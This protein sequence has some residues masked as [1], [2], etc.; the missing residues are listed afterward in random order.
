MAVS[1]SDAW[2]DLPPPPSA[3]DRPAADHMSA[4]ASR[5][6]SPVGEL[7]EDAEL[8]TQKPPPSPPDAAADRSI[9]AYPHMESMLQEFR[10]WRQEESRRCTVYLAVGGILF[11]ILFIYIDR[12]HQQVRFMNNY[13]L[14]GRALNSNI[15]AESSHTPYRLPP[16]W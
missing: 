15:V 6:A 10:M 12:L 9:D 11:A 2:N 8:I 3:A 1:L 5:T 14:Q 4:R 13:V 7:L 16:Q